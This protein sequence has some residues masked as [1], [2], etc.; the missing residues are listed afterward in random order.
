MAKTDD[1]DQPW[2][3][4]LHQTLVALGISQ[5]AYV[6]DAGHKR[7]IQLLEDDDSIESIALALSS[8]KQN[9]ETD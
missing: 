5:A 9:L 3:L 1:A 7:L 2:A 8:Y 6:P 4:P